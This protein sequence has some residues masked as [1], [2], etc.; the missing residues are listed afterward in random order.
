MPIS[1]P[2]P[3]WTSIKN[4]PTTVGGFGITDMASQNVASAASAASAAAV[5]WSGVSSK[6]TTVSGFGITDLASNAV[7]SLNGQVGA[8][9]DTTYGAVG[10]YLTAMATPI[11]AM[12][13]SATV[14]ATYAG[15]VLRAFRDDTVLNGGST[16]ATST[17]NAPL[18]GLSGTWRLLTGF[19]NVSGFAGCFGGLF[20][21]IS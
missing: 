5:P 4:K 3:S 16:T 10:S 1:A 6:P 21:R 18:L 15:S 13:A 7:T 2:P 9:T 8:V 11:P 17:G 12:G 14:G 19:S 20:V